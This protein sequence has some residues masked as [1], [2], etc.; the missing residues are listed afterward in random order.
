[1]ICLRQNQKEGKRKCGHMVNLIMLVSFKQENNIKPEP[2]FLLMY[3]IQSEITTHSTFVVGCKV[4]ECQRPSCQGGI[5]FHNTAQH[6]NWALDIYFTF[7]FH[8]FV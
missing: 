5:I 6:L 4:I 7:L 1:M 3:P 8:I 2:E